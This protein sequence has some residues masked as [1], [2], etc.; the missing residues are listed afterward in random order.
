MK[1]TIIS[2][3]AI[4]HRLEYIIQA[5][6]ELGHEVTV[7]TSDFNHRTK[8]K[9]REK[10]KEYI[11]IDTK[12]Y[13]KNMS[14]QRIYSHYN[15]SKKVMKQLKIIKSDIIY[16]MIPPNFLVKHI[17]KYKDKNKNIKIIFDIIDLWP[18][19]LP[20][21]NLK[22]VLAAVL[23]YW[24]NLRDKNLKKADYVVTEC[25][26]YQKRLKDK[27][28]KNTQTLY[29]AEKYV[30]YE[31][32]INVN[33][34]D[35]AYLGSINNIIDIELIINILNEL[36]KY[37]NI[38]FHVIGDGEKRIKLIEQLEEKKI[39][40]KYYGKIYDDKIKAS[41]FN[42]CCFGINVMKTTTCVGLT[43]KSIDYFK[44]GLPIL[45]NIKEDTTNIVR[46]Y[47]VGFNVNRDNLKETIKKLSTME[48]KEFIQ[49]KKNVSD[50]YQKEFEIN[51]L[52]NKVKS[53]IKNI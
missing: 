46:Q 14:F 52:K 23:K 9:I 22:I 33:E 24:S 16:A 51:I 49:L 50:M 40:Y 3:F 4:T 44:F 19:T 20:N 18:E 1:V 41:I 32:N 28:P 39:P 15:F 48:E 12:K 27:L 25:E 37:K 45:N 31:D 7:L 35:I 21:R 6:K 43:L 2:C 42:K 34:L 17:I 47:N 13:N 38:R 30:G 36:K 11:Y 26:L 8:E 10:N 53:I 5:M 29:L